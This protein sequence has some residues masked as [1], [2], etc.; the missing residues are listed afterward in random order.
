MLECARRAGTHPLAEHLPGPA[1]GARRVAADLA[2]QALQDV[3]EDGASGGG[4][5]RVGSR[6]GTAGPR[7]GDAHASL[8]IAA[9]AG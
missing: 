8:G 5:R 2:A 7:M 3:A 4:R 6:G 9:V 1:D